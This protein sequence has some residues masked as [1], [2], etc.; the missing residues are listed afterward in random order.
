MKKSV[1]M[2]FKHRIPENDEKY[3]STDNDGN[4]SEVTDVDTKYHDHT[5]QKKLIGVAELPHNEHFYTGTSRRFAEIAQAAHDK[6]LSTE[7]FEDRM[8]EDEIQTVRDIEMWP[9]DE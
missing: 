2:I 8:T 1:R 6:G 4:Y 3:Y 9:D 7:W 5:V